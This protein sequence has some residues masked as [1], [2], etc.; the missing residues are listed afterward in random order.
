LRRSPFPADNDAHSQAFL[1]DKTLEVAARQSFSPRI[2]PTLTLLSRKETEPDVLRDPINNDRIEGDPESVRYVIGNGS[3][4][5]RQSCDALPDSGCSF[6]GRAAAVKQ[7]AN[8]FVAG[9]S[10]ARARPAHWTRQSK[11]EDLL[12]LD[13]KANK[14]PRP[15]HQFPSMGWAGEI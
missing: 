7:Q 6:A 9:Q 13:N 8:G 5:E 4:V 2:L 11:H 10:G 1:N 15:V 12:S 3:V 14:P